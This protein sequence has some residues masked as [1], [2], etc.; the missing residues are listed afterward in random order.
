M[1]LDEKEIQPNPKLIYAFVGIKAQPFGDLTL[2]VIAVGK[3]L[4]VTFV[5]VE[6][7]SA[8]NAIIGIN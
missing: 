6:A 1:K 3:T 7:L 8:Y 2:P 4:F 5:V